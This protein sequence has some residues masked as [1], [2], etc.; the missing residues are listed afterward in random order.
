MR[1]RRR[2]LLREYLADKACADCGIREL[3]VLEF[4]HLRDKTSAVSDM[5]AHASWRR[6]LAEIARCDV[7][8]ANCHPRR[9]ARAFGWSK[10]LGLSEPRLP[11]LPS[12][13]SPAYERVKSARS[14]LSRRWRNRSLLMDYLTAHPCEG[15]GVDDPVVLDFDHLTSKLLD[16]S[17]LIVHEGAS[18]VS[19]VRS[20]SA[21]CCARTATA[22]R[23]PAGAGRD[24]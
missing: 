20:A 9:T 7:V 6:I 11:P 23:R 8:C 17:Q 1:S 3:A 14:R 19:W 5:V 22:A 24:R 4:D 13:A 10:V 12:R 21:A 15:C 16:V 18:G 2:A